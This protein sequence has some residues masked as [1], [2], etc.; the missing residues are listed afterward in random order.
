MIKRETLRRRAAEA[1]IP[2]EQTEAFLD[3]ARTAL[4]LTPKH[5]GPLVGRYGGVPP[6][7]PGVA[8]PVQHTEYAEGIPLRFLAEIECAKLPR[9]ADLDVT[10]P[11]TGSLLFFSNLD[12]YTLYE[13]PEKDLTAVMHVETDPAAEPPAVPVIEPDEGYEGAQ[14]MVVI[15]PTPLYAAV[16]LDLPN[17]EAFSYRYRD[18]EGDALLAEAH[19]D[20][21]LQ[22]DFVLRVPRYAE[23]IDISDDLWDSPPDRY[24]GEMPS[25]LYI[26]GYSTREQDPTEYDVSHEAGLD[27]GNTMSEAELLRT[28]RRDFALLAEFSLPGPNSDFVKARYHIRR[29]DL[30]AGRF[31]RVVPVSI[32]T[33]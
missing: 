29:A 15:E 17:W 3:L 1:G 25:A 22:R 9:P 30:A 13:E 7:P 26:G 16:F 2:T 24:N 8:W 18:L 21:D 32:F 19:E 23:L 10:L 28:V 11:A 4:C 5:V 6:L 33:E 20:Y 14:G 31:D 12:V 27:P